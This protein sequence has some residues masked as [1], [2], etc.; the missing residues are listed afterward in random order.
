V[1]TFFPAEPGHSI[2]SVI[3]SQSRT[4][5]HRQHWTVPV[6]REETL[7]VREK[8]QK[9]GWRPP[10]HKPKTKKVVVWAKNVWD[11]YLI[12]VDLQVRVRVADG[13]L[14]DIV[15]ISVLILIN[16][17]EK[18]DPPTSKAGSTGPNVQPRRRRTKP[19]ASC[20]NPCAKLTAC[21]PSGPWTPTPC[22]K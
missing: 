12:L 10:N 22:N 15:T 2:M 16:T 18:A 7:A 20:G 17:Y 1:S 19:S 13:V 3:S 8:F 9:I 4:V 21:W 11:R 6:S 5:S 14:L